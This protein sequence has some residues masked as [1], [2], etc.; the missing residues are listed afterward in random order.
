VSRKVEESEYLE[1]EGIV[2]DYD[3]KN[4]LKLY[5]E[6]I[7]DKASSPKPGKSKFKKM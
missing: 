5:Y 4:F 3:K 2:L 7:S 1:E 6:P